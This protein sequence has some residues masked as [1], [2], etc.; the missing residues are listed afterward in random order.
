M[1]E[2]VRKTTTA[3]ALAL[4]A[5]LLTGCGGADGTGGSAGDKGDAGAGKTPTAEQPTEKPAGKPADE[6]GAAHEVTIEVT[7]KGQ[8]M[9]MYTLDESKTETVTLPWKRT[10][11]IT[12]EGA[13]KQVG[14]LV[15]VTPG[16]SQGEDGMLKAAGCTITVD[17]KKV[18]DNGDGA[19]AKPC[20]Y[21]LK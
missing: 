17:G 3:V 20:S 1:G 21:K 5:A 18:A 10:A 9:I 2:I 13:E 8:T 6:G 15:I 7:G 19:V 14:R 4:A 16:H 11:T 12:P